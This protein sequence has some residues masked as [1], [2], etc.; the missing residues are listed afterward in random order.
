MSSSA[1]K[2]AIY[3]C[4]E[5]FELKQGAARVHIV[6]EGDGKHT[7]NIL[8]PFDKGDVHLCIRAALNDAKFP[9]FKSSSPPVNIDYP[10][11]LRR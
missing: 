5:E 10:F 4:G 1:E 3:E 8:P 6:L 9:R 2:G 11:V 7:I